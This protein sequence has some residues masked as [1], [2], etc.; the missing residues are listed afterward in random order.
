MEELDRETKK[1]LAAYLVTFNT[2]EGQTVLADLKKSFFEKPFE[3]HRVNE[4][5]YLAYR[6][7]EHN[8]YLKIIR[9]RE[10]AAEEIQR[11]EGVTPARTPDV[12]I[13]EP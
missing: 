11:T 7:A 8:V 1:V 9:M 4:H 3:E 6:A 10:R 13:E 12:I 5:G 2:P